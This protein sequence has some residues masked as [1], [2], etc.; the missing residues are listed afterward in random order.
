[1]RERRFFRGWSVLIALAL[2]YAVC[3]GIMGNCV[4]VIFAAIIKDRGF[5]AS[6]LSLYYSVKSIVS[7]LAVGSMVKFFFSSRRPNIIF[8]VLGVVMSVSFGIMALFQNVWQWYISAV[9]GG[10][11]SCTIGVILPVIINNWFQVNQ[12]TLIGVTFMGSGLVSAVFSPI[13]SKIIENFGWRTACLVLMGI[14]IVGW[15]IPALVLVVVSPETVGLHPLGYDGPGAMKEKETAGSG[16]VPAESIFVLSILALLLPGGL[17]SLNNQL[18]TFATS[19]GYTLAVGAT[20]TSCAM[21]GNLLSKLAIGVI[22][23]R[24]GGM[25]AV[26]IFMVL[27]ALGI[28]LILTG[29]SSGNPLFL[30]AG[31]FCFGSTFAV[32]VTSPSLVY[33]DI[34]G[35]EEYRGRLSR[36]QKYSMLFGTVSSFLFPFIYDKTGTWSPVFVYGFF[37]SIA[38]VI[39]VSYI[40][41]KVR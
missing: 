2:I 23:D 28:A 19:S 13:A 30:Y 10:I 25:S 9:L 8:A 41:K 32:S 6:Q 31:A 15:V 20:I 39:L 29:I 24:M 14:G 36:Y 38:G 21:M 33:K 1:M 11:A 5:A 4:G 27:I 12:G 3:N 7:A 35:I 40:R 37:A 16:R 17:T 34:Y 18:A 26:R 22:S